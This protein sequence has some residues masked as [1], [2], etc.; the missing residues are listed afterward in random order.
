MYNSD[1]HQL[2]GADEVSGIIMV[3]SN[4]HTF[5]WWRSLNMHV[6]VVQTAPQFK[7]KNWVQICSILKKSSPVE[8]A[9]P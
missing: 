4:Y 1:L 9:L 8:G 6:T 5:F 7:C 3:A 2:P